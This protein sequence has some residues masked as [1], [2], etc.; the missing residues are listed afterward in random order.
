LA[1]GEG[2][3]TYDWPRR[4]PA[5]RLLQAAFQPE[6]VPDL[7]PAQLKEVLKALV[8]HPNLPS[9]AWIYTQYD[10]MVGAGT[11]GSAGEIGYAAALV[12]LPGASAGSG[13]EL[14]W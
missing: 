1:A 6:K 7:H 3:P 2:A 5:Y 10:R 4:E 13:Y 9:R 12:R 11:M 8:A 14:G